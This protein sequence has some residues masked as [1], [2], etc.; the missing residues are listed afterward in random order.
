MGAERSFSTPLLAA[1]IL[2]L[3]ALLFVLGYVPLAR[4][5]RCIGFDPVATSP[6]TGFICPLC[7]EKKKV[8]WWKSYRWRSV[9]PMIGA[10]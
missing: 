5:P 2:S 4:C 8:S 10:P 6:V 1:S 3:A 9:R 7:G